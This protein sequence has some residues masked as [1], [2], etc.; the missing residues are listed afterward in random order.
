M[1]QA[2]EHLIEVF[3]YQVFELCGHGP[4]YY[5]PY[6]KN[7]AVEDYLVLRLAGMVSEMEDFSM[8]GI[9]KDG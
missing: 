8:V 1:I 5:V 7:D 4:K 6:M 3:E 2:L 9:G